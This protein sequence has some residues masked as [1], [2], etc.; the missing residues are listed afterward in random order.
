ME[1]NTIRNLGYP[2]LLGLSVN[3]DPKLCRSLASSIIAG[4]SNAEFDLQVRIETPIT[5]YCGQC[6]GEFRAE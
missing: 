3:F 4:I 6:G 5:N 2:R 1:T